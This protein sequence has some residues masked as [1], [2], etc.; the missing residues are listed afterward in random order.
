MASCQCM[1]VKRLG[2]QLTEAPV[3]C[4]PRSF[5]CD[6]LANHNKKKNWAPTD[7]AKRKLIS[8]T[9][10]STRPRTRPAN[11]S[12]SVRLSRQTDRPW[13]DRL[14]TLDQLLPC[15]ILA[16]GLSLSVWP[17]LVVAG[18]CS[19]GP[20]MFKSQSPVDHSSLCQN[21]SDLHG[22]GV[23]LHHKHRFTAP[24]FSRTDHGDCTLLRQRSQKK[25]SSKKP[26]DECR[27]KLQTL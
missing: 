20:N 25:L 1:P 12:K 22:C 24:V 14:E 26:A 5:E 11:E 16:G 13:P 4:P 18:L 2:D 10:Q 27:T 6:L 17:N 8:S 7:Q 3:E 23:T 19:K 15:K 9:A 21:L